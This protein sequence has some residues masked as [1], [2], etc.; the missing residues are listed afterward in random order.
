M[1]FFL[2]LF[3]FYLISMIFFLKIAKRGEYLPAGADMASGEAGE[4]TRDAWD[5]RAGATRL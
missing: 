4:P 5:H 2:I 3:D 1:P